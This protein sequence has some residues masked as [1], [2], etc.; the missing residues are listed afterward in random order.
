MY[1]Y[2]E[3]PA[4]VIVQMCLDDTFRLCSCDA[5]ILTP[6]EIGWVLEVVDS[7]K[8]QN[9]KKGKLKL[10]S[11]ASTELMTVENVLAQLNSGTCCDFEVDSAQQYY[12]KIRVPSTSTSDKGWL[13]FSYIAG[14][15]GHSQNGTKFAPWRTQLMPC[16]QGTVEPRDG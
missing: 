2:S 12:L 14:R 9:I 13:E 10:P 16:R 7:S 11:W 15:W 5:D 1:Q 8:P 3:C 4:C 6:K